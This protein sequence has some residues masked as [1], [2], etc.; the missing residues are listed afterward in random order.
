MNKITK[1]FESKIGGG[2]INGPIPSVQSEILL[3]QNQASENASKC[4][5]VK[6]SEINV[7]LEPSRKKSDQF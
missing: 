2:A 7:R 6:C 4:S 1:Y 3:P 5:S